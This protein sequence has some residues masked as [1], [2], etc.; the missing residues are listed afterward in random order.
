[1]TVTCRVLPGAVFDRES[2]VELVMA[3]I[4]RL[5]G[6]AYDDS[7]IRG[8]AIQLGADA[9]DSVAVHG[10]FR[11]SFADSWQESGAATPTLV[12]GITKTNLEIPSNNMG[13]NAKNV[14]YQIQPDS[15]KVVQH[16]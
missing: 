4:N 10:T 1:M 12:G 15:I 8:L 5:S 6:Q 14:I 2:F 7:Y 9:V 16:G 11:L 13:L 3:Y